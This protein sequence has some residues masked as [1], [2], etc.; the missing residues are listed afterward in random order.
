MANQCTRPETPSIV[1]LRWELAH[2]QGP[3][4]NGEGDHNLEWNLGLWGFY[5]PTP[6]LLST[7]SPTTRFVVGEKFILHICKIIQKKKKSFCSIIHIS[8]TLLPVSGILWS[9]HL[10]S[11]W[12]SLCLLSKEVVST[13]FIHSVSLDFDIIQFCIYFS[14]AA[15]NSLTVSRQNVRTWQ[16]CHRADP[17][18]VWRDCD[19]CWLGTGFVFVD[20][21]WRHRARACEWV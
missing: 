1:S 8:I 18:D 17:Q 2:N 6:K 11:P 10:C 14:R 13:V 3:E 9:S 21:Q 19:A 16:G 20:F 15:R 5:M 7:S 4:M 12:T